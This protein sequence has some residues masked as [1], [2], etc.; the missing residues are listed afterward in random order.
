M[1]CTV[2]G[3]ETNHGISRNARQE[4]R[5]QKAKENRKRTETIRKQREEARLKKEEE[6]RAR[7]AKLQAE[8]RRRIAVEKTKVRIEV[9]SSPSKQCDDSR[10]ST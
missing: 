2:L 6:Q 9:S 7:E 1:R 10:S 8:N 4:L 3:A 5:A